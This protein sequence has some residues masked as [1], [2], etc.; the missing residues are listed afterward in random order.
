MVYGVPVH[1]YLIFVGESAN[2][3][4]KFMVSGTIFDIDSTKFPA[5]TI[6]II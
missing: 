6:K 1:D 5:L 3:F 4:W 2:F